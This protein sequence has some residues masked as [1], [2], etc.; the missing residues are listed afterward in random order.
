MIK[1]SEVKAAFA[2]VETENYAFRLYLKNHADED[3]LDEQFRTLHDELFAEYDCSPCRNC[4]REYSACIE[5]EEINLAAD[6]LGMSATEFKEK[7]IEEAPSE[8]LINAKPCCFLK[9]DGECQ[10]EA[11]KPESCRDFPYTDKPARLYTLLSTIEA[12]SICPVVFELLER[13]K[14]IYHFRKQ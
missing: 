5:D 3:E 10:I 12:A 4:C 1:S 13:L 14:Q 8:H 6:L 2:K 11:C 7:Y 9:E